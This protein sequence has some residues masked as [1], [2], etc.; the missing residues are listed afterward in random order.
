MD[1]QIGSG[2]WIDRWVD[3][4]VRWMYKVDGRNRKGVDRGMMNE[5]DGWMDRG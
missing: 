4:M 1:R 5:V 2:V 3:E